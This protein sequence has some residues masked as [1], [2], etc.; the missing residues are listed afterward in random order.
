MPT[1][2]ISKSLSV[3]I[4]EDLKKSLTE[5]AK[6]RKT[7]FSKILNEA[8]LEYLAYQKRVLAVHNLQKLKQEANQ[9]EGWSAEEELIELEKIKISKDFFKIG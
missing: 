4:D 6:E 8:V 9:L 5:L 3:R 2:K 1:K 7:S